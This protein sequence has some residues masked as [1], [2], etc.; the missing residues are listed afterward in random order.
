MRPGIKKFT[1]TCLPHLS[2]CPVTTDDINAANDIFG[3]NLGSIK[4]KTVHRPNPHVNTNILPVPNDIMSLHKQ[5]TLAI[6]IMFV[7]KYH[8]SLLPHASYMLVLWKH[9]LIEN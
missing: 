2:D 8:S 1:D 9:S 4:G 3:K 7:N 6:D 5:V